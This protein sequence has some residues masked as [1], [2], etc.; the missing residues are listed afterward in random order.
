MRDPA[1]IK[2]MCD[3]LAEAWARTPD[4]RFFQFLEN[5]IEGQCSFHTEDYEVEK[6]LRK[7]AGR[8]MSAH[9]YRQLKDEN[10]READRAWSEFNQAMFGKKPV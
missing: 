9:D 6:L 10:E 2:R 8:P 5:Y 4:Q 7:L 1:R 3:L